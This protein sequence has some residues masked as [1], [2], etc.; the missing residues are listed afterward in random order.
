MTGDRILSRCI[1]HDG[2]RQCSRL[3]RR[4]ANAAVMKGRRRYGHRDMRLVGFERQCSACVH[5]APRCDP[6]N[7]LLRLRATTRYSSSGTSADRRFANNPSHI[8]HIN[9]ML[10]TASNCPMVVDLHPS[11]IHWAPVPVPWCLA[12]LRSELADCRSQPHAVPVPWPCLPRSSAAGVAYTSPALTGEHWQSQWP[13]PR[14]TRRAIDADGEH[15]SVLR[16]A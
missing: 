12:R 2:P 10:H 5:G 1:M 7:A 13:H 4:V 14:P 15:A 11:P 16:S 8:L 6:A 9:L 3:P